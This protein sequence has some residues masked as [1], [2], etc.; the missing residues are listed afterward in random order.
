M[1]ISVNLNFP[2]TPVFGLTEAHRQAVQ[3]AIDTWNSVGRGLLSIRQTALAEDA[4]IRVSWIPSFQNDIVGFTSY[5][6]SDSKDLRV[7]V[8]L[9]LSY[10]DGRIIPVGPTRRIAVH[11]LGHALGLWAHSDQPGD[12]M[13]Q[14]IESEDTGIS[15]R[16][17]NTLKA[18]YRA[19]PDTTRVS[20]VS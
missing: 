18:L 20:A 19:V 2:A 7:L 4:D 17:I 11:E 10:S 15:L 8:R 6:A 13:F 5:T 9:P 3:A 14:S 12:I 16:D 1:P